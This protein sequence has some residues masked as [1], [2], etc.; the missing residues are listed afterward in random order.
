[1][2][3]VFTISCKNQKSE[4]QISSSTSTSKRDLELAYE[5]NCAST[6]SYAK[7]KDLCTTVK[8]FLSAGKETSTKPAENNLEIKA[9]AVRVYDLAKNLENVGQKEVVVYRKSSQTFGKK[10]LERSYRRFVRDLYIEHFDQLV[11]LVDY[12]LMD[13]NKEIA[14]NNRKLNAAE[15]TADMKTGLQNENKYYQEMIPLLNQLKI[16][17]QA[18]VNLTEKKQGVKHSRYVLGKYDPRFAK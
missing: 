10:I 18:F 2:V 17:V 1:M 3:T 11:G 14:R 13:H 12:N 7:L 6:D 8:A 15:T 4:S 16:V 9:A 5:K